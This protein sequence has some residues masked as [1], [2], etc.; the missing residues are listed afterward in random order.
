MPTLVERES[1]TEDELVERLSLLNELLCILTD[2]SREI[3]ERAWRE[4]IRLEH[5][6]CFLLSNYPW[7]DGAK[8][9]KTPM[10]FRST[11]GKTWE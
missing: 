10:W 11:Y 8:S 2:H 3:Q 9:Y 1:P 4:V 6:G 7:A 5:E